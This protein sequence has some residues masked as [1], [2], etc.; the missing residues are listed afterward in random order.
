MSATNLS[1]GVSAI[2]PWLRPGPGLLHQIPPVARNIDIRWFQLAEWRLM[3]DTQFEK[4]K[5]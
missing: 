5:P 4:R 3:P 1:A 2:A